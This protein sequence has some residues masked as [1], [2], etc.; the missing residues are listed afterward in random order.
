MKEFVRVGVVGNESDFV[1]SINIKE[2]RVSISGKILTCQLSK[3][4]HVIWFDELMWAL[5]QLVLQ[6]ICFYYW[7]YY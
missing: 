7:E 1:Y 5:G 6:L 2:L 3:K 4:V